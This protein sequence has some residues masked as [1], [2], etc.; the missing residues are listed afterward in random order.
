MNRR[1]SRER[2]PQ[3]GGSRIDPDFHRRQ[4]RFGLVQP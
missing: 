1:N 2:R 4:I 3:E